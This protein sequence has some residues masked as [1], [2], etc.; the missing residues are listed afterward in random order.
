MTPKNIFDPDPDGVM[1]PE[2]IF[3]PDPGGVKPGSTQF[4]TG[5]YVPRLT[6]APGSP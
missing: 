6:P 3:D 5:V 4:D 1:T 2:N